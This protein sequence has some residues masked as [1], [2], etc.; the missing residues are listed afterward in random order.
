MP[1]RPA[2]ATTNQSATGDELLPKPSSLFVAIAACPAGRLERHGRMF[3]GMRGVERRVVAQR[4]GQRTR[5]KA[6]PKAESHPTSCRH[7]NPPKSIKR[8]G[9]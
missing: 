2:T 3:F 6:E 1:A 4:D 7:D 8:R 9:T 5:P